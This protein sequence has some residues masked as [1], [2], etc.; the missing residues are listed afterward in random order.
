M[1]LVNYSSMMVVVELYLVIY[2][3]NRDVIYHEKTEFTL[4]VN[5]VNILY[6]NKSAKQTDLGC[7]RESGFYC[8]LTK[9]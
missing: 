8:N 1:Q 2:Y 4:L 6:L 3:E 5:S 7:W 9:S